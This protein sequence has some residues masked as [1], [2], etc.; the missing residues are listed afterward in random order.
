V[1]FVP[2]GFTARGGYVYYSD[3]KTPGGAHPGT[4]SVLRQSSADVVASGVQDGDLLA[5]TE[6]G[7]LV[8]AVHCDMS[9]Q[10][11][12]VVTTPST[13]HGEGHL[14]FTMNALPPSL[15][16]SP[17][18]IVSPA[19]ASHS[20]PTGAYVAIAA[21]VLAAVVATMAASRRRRR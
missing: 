10:V 8:I 13:A 5:A 14:V 19:D 18:A 15:S 4:D 12:P 16:P 20:R 1:A 9:C 17:Q 6:G 21:G 2:P 3:R 7:A 11:I